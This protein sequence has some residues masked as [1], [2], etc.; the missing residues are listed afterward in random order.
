[1]DKKCQY[2]SQQLRAHA[3]LPGW[4][5]YGIAKTVRCHAKEYKDGWCKEHH[6]ET[7]L[8]AVRKRGLDNLL[9]G[10]FLLIISILGWL[11]FDM[12]GLYDPFGFICSG[13]AILMAFG[14][15]PVGM[16]EFFFG[17]EA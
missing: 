2:S 9:W 15:I 13:M 4:G 7:T 17:L 10:V 14:L 1:M 16:Y 12:I 5:Q 11:F 8:L 3:R 6:P